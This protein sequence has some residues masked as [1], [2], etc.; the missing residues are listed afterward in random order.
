MARY[1]R[2]KLPPWA[3]NSIIVIER[4]TLP[5]LIFQLIRTML[6]PTS[7]DVFLLGILVG[8]FIAFYLEWI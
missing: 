7:F 3:R 6:F 4:V 5:I 1:Y 8:I 2:Y